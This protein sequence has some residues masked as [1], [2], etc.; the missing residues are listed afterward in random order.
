MAFLNPDA[1]RVLEAGM[2]T[3]EDTAGGWLGRKTGKGFYE[4]EKETES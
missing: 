2:A 4:Y 3:K 1:I